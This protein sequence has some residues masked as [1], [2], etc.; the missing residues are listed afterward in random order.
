MR[1]VLLALSVV[2]ALLLAPGFQ[3]G[4][5]AQPVPCGAAFLPECD[6]QCPS[7][8][9]CMSDLMGSC[10]CVGGSI[11][12]PCGGWAGPPECWGECPDS[13][14]PICAD[15]GGICGCVVPTLSEWGII[16]MALVM[17]G[18]VLVL[19]RRRETGRAH[20]SD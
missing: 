16:G 20:A 14:L 13:N 9:T 3:A 1:N 19:R 12:K 18:G 11:R 5:Q 7:G 4:V 8:E 15:V 17:F 6:G 2:A 10:H